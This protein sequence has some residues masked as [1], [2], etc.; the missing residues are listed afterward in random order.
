MTRQLHVDNLTPSSSCPDHDSHAA[1]TNRVNSIQMLLASSFA[2]VCRATLNLEVMGH[3][4]CAVSLHCKIQQTLRRC[5]RLTLALSTAYTPTRRQAI[6]CRTKLQSM[7][8]PSR[9][10]NESFERSIT[11]RRT[12]AP[13]PPCTTSMKWTNGKGRRTASEVELSLL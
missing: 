11:R 13:K 7:Q 5:V 8:S 2:A 10:Q 4:D 6:H 3:S 1:S 9:T 12:Q